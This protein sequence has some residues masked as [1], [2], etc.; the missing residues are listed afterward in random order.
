MVDAVRI[1]PATPA[2]AEEILAVR[3]AAFADVA[4]QYGDPDL[5]PLRDTVEAVREE[6]T[7][8]TLLKAVEGGRIVGAVRARV[9]GGV[10]HIGRLAVDPPLQRRGIGTALARAIIEQF[11]DAVRFELFTGHLSE[12]P[13][14][15][16]RKLGFSETHQERESDNVTLVHME[17]PGRIR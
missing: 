13:L 6:S 1:E 17:R 11:P 9:V 5:P 2:D 14:A 16:Y 4:E 10:V 3:L 7:E 8:H 15:I 12:G